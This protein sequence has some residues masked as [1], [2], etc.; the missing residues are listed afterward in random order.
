MKGG[1]AAVASKPSRGI[2]S[3]DLEA[4]NAFKDHSNREVER[5]RRNLVGLSEDDQ[6]SLVVPKEEQVKSMEDAVK[7]NLDF[8]EKVS[9]LVQQGQATMAADSLQLVLQA[10]SSSSKGVQNLLQSFVREWS[11][12]GLEER[13]VC[14]ERLLGALDGHLGKERAAASNSGSAAPQV[15]CPGSELGRLAFEVASRGYNCEACEGRPLNYFGAEFIRKH[16]A[17]LKAQTIHP[18]AL[19]TC[20]RWRKGDHVREIPIPEVEVPAAVFPPMQLG[21]FIR[22]Y[23]NAGARASFDAVLTA[24]ALD[25]SV[26]IFRY[27]RTVAHV[28]RE[29]GIWANFG[30]LAYD[31]DHDEAHGQCVELSWEE[32][33]FAVGHFFEIREEDFVDAFHAANSISMMQIKYTCVYFSAVRNGTP[34]PGIGGT[35]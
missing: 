33:K 25:T 10:S 24:F 29:G 7:A 26:N 2:F 8:L 23:D 12:E 35:E 1:A 32:L 11:Q 9:E 6:A 4:L 22:L 17:K 28:V 13:S 14:F 3:T 30:P 19:N 18:F 16:G 27:I 15:L 20:N 34:A 31:T 5:V 21:E